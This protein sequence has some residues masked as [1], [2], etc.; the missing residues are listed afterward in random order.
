MFFKRSQPKDVLYLIPVDAADEQLPEDKI[1]MMHSDT[2]GNVSTSLVGKSEYASMKKQ[3]MKF[4]RAHRNYA[5]IGLEIS[6]NVLEPV[7]VEIGEEDVWALEH[8]LEHALKRGSIPDVLKRYIKEIIKLGEDQRQGL[9]DKYEK[10]MQIQKTESIPGVLYRLPYYSE[11]DIEVSIPIYKAEF[12]YPLIILRNLPPNEET[13]QDMQRI[14]ILDN[15]GD[16]GISKIPLQLI[17][18]AENN[19]DEWQSTNGR[20]GCLTC[21]RNRDGIIVSYLP[22]NQLQ[23]RALD[24][25]VKYF[26]ETG[27][28][29]KPVSKTAQAVLDKARDLLSSLS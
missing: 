15:E 11:A 26:E 3:G 27:H 17:A 18:E 23:R 8:I 20:D 14:L 16:L 7:T 13:E 25:I 12:H 28:G 5:T 2:K 22:L 21:L 4:K 29:K 6:P 24:T 1:M 9:K 10:S 19:L